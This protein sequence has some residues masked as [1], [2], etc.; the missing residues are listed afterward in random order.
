MPEVKYW[1]YH[2][3]VDCTACD[4]EAIRSEQVHREFLKELVKRIDMVAYG[5]PVMAHFANHDP[6]KGGYTIVQMIETSTITGHFV[7]A[8]GEAYI[9]IFSCK[10][11]DTVDAGKVIQEFYKP[12]TMRPQ[13]IYRK[14]L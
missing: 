2:L 8:N 7:D 4:K 13:F 1:G 12:T 6:T 3:T 11:F 9:D 5:D 10:L 14:A